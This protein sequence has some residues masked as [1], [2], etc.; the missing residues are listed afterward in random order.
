VAEA[1]A[2]IARGKVRW[3][4][5]RIYLFAAQVAVMAASVGFAKTFFSPLLAG[6]FS[7]PPIVYI[8]GMFL[9]GWVGF[10]LFQSVLIQRAQLRLHRRLGGLGAALAAGVVFSTIGIVLYSRRRMA[11][12]GDY[13]GANSQLLIVLLDLAVFGLLIGFAL[14][15]RKRPEVHRRLMLLSLV[16]ALAP[17]WFRFRHYFPS[18]PHPLIWFGLLLADSLILVAALYDYRRFGRVHPVYLFVGVP[19]FVMHTGEVTLTETVS[20]EKA[21]AALGSLLL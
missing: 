17:A 7:A 10:F 16:Q 19:L 21:A 3:E 15:N 1:Q 11:A 5:P 20:F 2:V 18:V 13:L 6:T 12:A 9:F 14:S 4:R 8:H